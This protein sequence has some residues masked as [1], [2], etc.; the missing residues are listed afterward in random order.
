[1]KNLNA[2]RFSDAATR[3]DFTRIVDEAENLDPSVSVLRVKVGGV[4]LTLAY[5]EVIHDAVECAR[6]GLAK[7]RFMC[8]TC[9]PVEGFA[10]E[11]CDGQRVF[12][13]SGLAVVVH[14]ADQLDGGW[15]VIFGDHVGV[16][17][18]RIEVEV[19][20]F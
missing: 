3:V 19:E 2:W 13:A 5:G 17:V 16:L 10:V 20:L 7:D 14:S 15:F 12:K 18:D 1:M 9:V 11:T 8:A 4:T 6:P